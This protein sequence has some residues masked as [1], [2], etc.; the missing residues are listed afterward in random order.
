MSSLS[1]VEMLVAGLGRRN[2]L[3]HTPE[4][5]KIVIISLFTVIIII[6][7]NSLNNII[8]RT[9]P[10]RIKELSLEVYALL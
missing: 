8:I 4:D 10:G 2:N 5:N 9:S 1:P 3:F 7:I 6:L